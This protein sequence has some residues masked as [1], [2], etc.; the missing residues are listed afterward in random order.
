M[1]ECVNYVNSASLQE[2][3][4]QFGKKKSAKHTLSLSLSL[5][6]SLCLTYT[7]STRRVLVEELPT[8]VKIKPFKSLF[9]T[10]NS[11]RTQCSGNST[12]CTVEVRRARVKCSH[13]IQ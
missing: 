8:V 2:T 7:R 10:D 11:K 5:S 13:K 12:H 4:L 6:L 1:C 3:F 9:K